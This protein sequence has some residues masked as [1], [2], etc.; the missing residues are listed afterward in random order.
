MGETTQLPIILLHVC[1]YFIMGIAIV[2]LV[3]VGWLAV[4][5]R[6]MPVK[7]AYRIEFDCPSCGHKAELNNSAKNFI[8]RC[9]ECETTVKGEVDDQ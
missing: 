1:A 3:V 2:F 4:K 7:G 5:G 6:K 9:P 8:W